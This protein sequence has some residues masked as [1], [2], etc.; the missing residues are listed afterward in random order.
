MKIKELLSL[1]N[2]LLPIGVEK[3]REIIKSRDI[4]RD[5]IIDNDI[6]TINS[7]IIDKNMYFMRLISTICVL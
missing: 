1:S 6:T 7:K 2:N 4:A 5:A 3:P